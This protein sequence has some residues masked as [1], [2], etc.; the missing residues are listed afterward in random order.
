MLATNLESNHRGR[1]MPE[2][3]TK[4]LVCN[5]GSSSLKFSLFDAEDELLLADGG[6][7]WLTKP[8]PGLS[9]SRSKPAGNPRGV[10]AGK[11]R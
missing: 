2:T 3:K 8:A 10:E 9:L 7:D 5:A 4:I 11:T 6:W 1:V